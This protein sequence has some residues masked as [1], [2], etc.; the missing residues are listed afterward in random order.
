MSTPHH[1]HLHVPLTLRAGPAFRVIE[2]SANSGDAKLEVF[3]WEETKVAHCTLVPIVQPCY[4]RPLINPLDK[5]GVEQR[6]TLNM[7]HRVNPELVLS[8]QIDY[9][10]MPAIRSA[11]YLTV[12][13]HPKRLRVL[14]N[15]ELRVDLPGR[16]KWELGVLPLNESWK[17]DLPALFF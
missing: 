8:V 3:T 10:L 17:V 5:L 11:G 1:F 6:Y 16:T 9:A 7:M 13:I 2:I 4:L 15:S 12:E 14:I